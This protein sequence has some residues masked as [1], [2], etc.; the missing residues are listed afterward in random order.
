MH[1]WEKREPELC[2]SSAPKGARRQL[3]GLG[4]EA[5]RTSLGVD[6][7]LRSEQKLS[8]RPVAVPLGRS[9]WPKRVANMAYN[10]ILI[11]DG[12]LEL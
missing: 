2:Q 6:V 11:K 5:N 8:S 1:K 3:T 7:L 9:A 4:R 10:A 12:D